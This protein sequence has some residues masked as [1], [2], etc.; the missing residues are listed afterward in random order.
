MIQAIG[1]R[2]R[3][4]ALQVLRGV[5][6]TI[7]PGR[8]TAMVGPNGAGKTTLI[9]LILGLVRADSGVLR[10]DGAP[11]NGDCAY[12]ARI[13]Y[14]P[15]IAR[16]PENL[17][18]RELIAM[19][20]DLRGP[21]AATD[22][23]LAAAFNLEAHLDKPL[24]TLS[25]GTRQKINAVIAFLFHPEL[26]ILDEPTAGLDPVASSLLKDRILAERGQGRT[27]IIT[28]HV[29]SELE[30]LADDIVF[31]LEGKVRFAGGVADLLRS[32]RQETMERA[33]AELMRRSA[34]EVA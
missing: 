6:L 19:V 18:G 29:L 4:G 23:S 11:I 1:L 21:F 13:G 16:F 5:D 2:K 10:F 22:D 12:R 25:G 32:T 31:L 8:I 28:S 27:G 26:F 17:T 15:Q 24:R 33:V 7:H 20:R 14:M 30:E 34:L 3:F 9:K